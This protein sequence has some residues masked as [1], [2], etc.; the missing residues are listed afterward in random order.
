MEN[1]E[2][3]A[4]GLTSPDTPNKDN[5]IELVVPTTEESNEAAVIEQLEDRVAQLEQRLAIAESRA[6]IRAQAALKISQNQLVFTGELTLPLLDKDSVVLSF[7]LSSDAANKSTPVLIEIPVRKLP[8]ASDGATLQ[9]SATVDM[10]R[11]SAHGKPVVG[12]RYYGR[13]IVERL[14]LRAGAVVQVMPGESAARL[15]FSRVLDK[16]HAFAVG[17]Y[18]GEPLLTVV[19]CAA[20]LAEPLTYT[21]ESLGWEKREMVVGLLLRHPLANSNI[22]EVAAGLELEGAEQ[23]AGPLPI[24]VHT[25]FQDRESIRCVLR[26]VPEDLIPA[27]V[28]V[29]QRLQYRVTLA[30]HC[31]GQPKG[32]RLDLFVENPN[33]D[34]WEAETHQVISKN[35]FIKPIVADGRPLGFEVE[36]VAHGLTEPIALRVMDLEWTEGNLGMYG[37]V[38]QRLEDLKGFSCRIV[39]IHGDGEKRYIPWKLTKPDAPDRHVGRDWST[40]FHAANILGGLKAG[41][42]QFALEKRYGPLSAVEPFALKRHDGL[43]EKFTQKIIRTGNEYWLPVEI[44]NGIIG[45]R[46]IDASSVSETAEPRITHVEWVGDGKLS[47]SGTAH[48]PL[49]SIGGLQC[50]LMLQSVSSG[51]VNIPLRSVVANDGTIAWQADFDPAQLLAEKSPGLW[52]LTFAKR[53]DLQFDSEILVNAA[54][55]DASERLMKNKLPRSVRIIQGVG[56][57]IGFEVRQTADSKPAPEKR[58]R[59]FFR[60]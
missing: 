10:S 56:G 58:K 48:H 46:T 21:V 45:F 16:T 35:R 15:I 51:S 30:Y 14:G 60:R 52:Y 38:A 28:G 32:R 33:I 54:G 18:D 7:E 57:S 22:F 39:L 23:D 44:S 5:A 25:S 19:D 3:T 50:S 11:I 27:K 8:P 2:E 53:F 31:S 37:T 6:L 47:L 34:V 49:T 20:G 43:L 9:W 4:A 29:D 24:A 42:W 13:L 26:F 1:A 12:D 41:T 55:A 40:A 36:T 17:E 59:R